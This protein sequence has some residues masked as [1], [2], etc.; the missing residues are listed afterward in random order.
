MS[1]TAEP[2]SAPR[3]KVVYV[4][5]AGRSGST[6][7]GV[8]LGNCDGIFFAGE[9]ARWHRRRGVPLAGDERES[10]WMRVRAALGDDAPSL[11]REAALLQRSSVAFALR[12]RRARARLRGPYRESARMLFDA[13]AEVS[14]DGVIVDTSHFPRRAR[15]LQE[16]DAIDLHL[17]LLVR[18]PQGVIG[19]YRRRDVKQGPEFGTPRTI[20]YLWMTYLWSLPVFL[21]QPRARRMFVQHER[22]LEDPEGVLG[23]ILSWVGSDAAIPDLTALDT[24]TS[25]LGN[26]L[27]GSGVVS[28]RTEAERPAQRSLATALLMAPW[29]PVFALLRPAAGARRGSGGEVDSAS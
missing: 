8:A 9:L 14:G 17:L 10:F 28:L 7:L 2:A 26:R 23:E 6:I 24:G 15:E 19:A 4:M 16:L 29:R 12:A 18:D 25:F 27:A 11:G 13:I 3:T 20:A 1:R 22:F 21:R 5:G